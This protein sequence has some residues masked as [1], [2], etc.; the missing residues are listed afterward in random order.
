M[1]RLLNPWWLLA[2]LPVAA[3]IGIY[4]WRQLH[5]RAFAVR[6]TNVDL[7]SSL[8]P[9]GIGVR[10]HVSATAFLLALVVL[11]FGLTRPS[12][13]TKEPL[14]RATIMLAIDVS[15]SMQATDVAPTRIDAA[16]SA[17]S[18]F[19][20]QLPASFNVGLVSF[21]KTASV[22]VSPTKE[23][24]AIMQAI[25]GLTLQE[26]TAT[27]EAVFTS[28]DAIRT[29][30]A[31]GAAGPPPARI[32]LLSDGFRTAGRSLEDASA[33]ASAANVPVSTIAFGT[34][35]GV[36]RIG[37]TPQRVPVD[38][39]SLQ[40]VAEVTKGY[41][42]EAASKEELKRVYSDMGSSIGYRTKPQE[43]TQWYLGIGFLLAL[44][45]GALSLLW[46]SRLP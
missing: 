33:A 18:D 30:P 8:V 11:A 21:A 24:S 2:L 16:K 36:V 42:Y 9:K 19:V 28:L 31:D 15:L 1:I 34:D 37:N 38:R 10:R 25:D 29:V 39:P 43:I 41:F 26:S 40:K 44:C 23:R 3:V 22:L 46:G 17:A 45:A 7:L 13:D 20:R 6:F 5:R 12:V 14:E 35:D 27:G 4:V 32:V